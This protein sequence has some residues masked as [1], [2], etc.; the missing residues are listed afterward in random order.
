MA[1]HCGGNWHG[2]RANVINRRDFGR[3][4]T[5]SSF[6]EFVN[7]RGINVAEK[8]FDGLILHLGVLDGDRSLKN[9]D[10]LSILI[11][12]SLNVFCCPE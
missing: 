7:Q 8:I 2:F 9:T 4:A 6:D 1:G 3:V 12:N 10:S 5:V 11:E